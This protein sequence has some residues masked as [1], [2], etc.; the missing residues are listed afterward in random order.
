MDWKLLLKSILYSILVILAII[1]LGI[2]I[3]ILHIIFGDL[4]YFIG[5]VILMYIILTA[6][7]YNIHKE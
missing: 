2:I 4:G 6:A 5:L 3:A 1:L 7:F